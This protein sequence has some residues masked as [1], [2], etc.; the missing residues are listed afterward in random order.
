MLHD[1]NATTYRVSPLSCQ[2]LIRQYS[3]T[4][5]GTGACIT[6]NRGSCEEFIEEEGLLR[7]K[8]SFARSK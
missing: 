2:I 1:A 5:K 6:E 7:V 4:G 8:G 3:N